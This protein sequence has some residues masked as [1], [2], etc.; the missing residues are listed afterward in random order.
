MTRLLPTD[1]HP[2]PPVRQHGGACY[3]AGDWSV[4][5]LAAPG[6]VAARRQA[7]PREIN[8]DG[9][10]WDLLG[11]DR[12][13]TVGAHLI[14]QAWGYRLP[15]RVRLSDSQRVV[16]EALARNPGEHR[17]PPGRK[18]HRL[19]WIRALGD[20]MALALENGQA[21]LTMLGRLV[22][23]LLALVRGQWPAPWG[24]ISAQVYRTGAQA[25]GITALVGFLI[26]IVLSYLSAQQLR[27]F[28]ADRFIVQLLGVSVVRELGP[29]LAAILVAGRSGSAITAQIGVMR[30]T[31]ELDAMR[32]MG[33]SHSRRLILPRVAALSLTMP[34]LVLW[35]DAMALLG[36]MLAA[37]AQLGIPV[38]WF[39]QALPGAISLTNYGI[40]L[41]KGA[42]FGVLIALVACHF[43]LRI[44]ANTE[45]LGRGTTASVVTSI[46]GV[47]LVD[48]L[49]AIVFSKVGM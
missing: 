20:A 11:V 19:D 47:I 31:Q 5:A 15:E 9:M 32:V 29:V 22:L 45:S 7:L 2:A 14:W 6:V 46:T 12:L 25:L 38:P 8:G 13:D 42:T 43:G 21:M 40:G 28:G 37:E 3:L 17:Q 33:I 10:R 23:D 36:G 41:L 4:Q 27:T 30:V 44:E 34:L 1:S 26:G 48:A 24:Q 16:F 39:L 49:Y 35:T 18:G